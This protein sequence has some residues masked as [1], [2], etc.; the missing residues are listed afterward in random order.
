ML[1]TI[2]GFLLAFG[3]AE[4]ILPM[5]LLG[6]VFHDRDKWCRTIYLTLFGMI[7][8]TYLKSIW[9]IPLASSIKSDSWAFPSGHMFVACLFYL[10]SSHEIKKIIFSIFS[11]MIILG[12]AF[13][14]IQKGYHDIYDVLG[15]IIFAIPTMFFYSMLIKQKSIKQNSELILI[16]LLPTSVILMILTFK[17]YNHTLWAIAGLFFFG[18]VRIIHKNLSAYFYNK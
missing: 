4:I 16:V 15:A 13:G 17:I 12:I 18:A 9:K 3:R 6:Y 8:V 10:W 14:L 7:L 5:A 2:F 1:D 11:A